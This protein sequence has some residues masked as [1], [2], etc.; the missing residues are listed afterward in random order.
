MFIHFWSCSGENSRGSGSGMLASSARCIRKYR[1]SACSA[2]GNC[3][4]ACSISASV[5]THRNMPVRLPLGNGLLPNKIRIQRTI[6]RIAGPER[7]QRCGYSS[8]SYGFQRS[9]AEI[10]ITGLSG[11][12][13][14]DRASLFEGDQSA[15]PTFAP[16]MTKRVD[17][18]ALSPM[19]LKTSK[20]LRWRG[21]RPIPYSRPNRCQPSS[22]GSMNMPIGGWI[23]IGIPEQTSIDGR[24]SRVAKVL[25]EKLEEF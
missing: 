9:F 7:R 23:D 16:A 14:S 10:S 8:D 2:P 20:C 22:S 4:A 19:K 13:L 5:F 21:E 3:W 18:S 12:Q 11:W 15:M 25:K 24:A 1:S 17:L 6:R